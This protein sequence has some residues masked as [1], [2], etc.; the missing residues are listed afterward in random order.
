MTKKRIAGRATERDRPVLFGDFVQPLA[1]GARQQRLQGIGNHGEAAVVQEGAGGPP[2]RAVGIGPNTAFVPHPCDEISGFYVEPINPRRIEMNEQSSHQKG[3][4]LYV[5]FG[6]V[7]RW[8]WPFDWG[9]VYMTK[10]RIDDTAPERD[11]PDIE[12]TPAM[13]WVVREWLGSSPSE[14]GSC[15]DSEI[16]HLLLKLDVLFRDGR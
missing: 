2:Q 15:I 16:D 6:S 11:R 4:G 9:I 13:R 1:F 14:G 7:Q 3:D 12:I 10:K 8:G 5:S